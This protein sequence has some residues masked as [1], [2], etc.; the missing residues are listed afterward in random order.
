MP[1]GT[2]AAILGSA[3][4]AG[5]ASALSSSSN[6]KAINAATDAQSQ[7]AAQ[8]AQLQREIY[9][10]NYNVLSPYAQSGYGANQAINA[11]L[12]IPQAN[13]NAQTGQA[14]AT[15]TG[16]NGVDWAAYVQGNQ[17]AMND[18]MR[19]HQ[20]MPLNA[21][22]AYHYIAD[23]S[24]RDLSA[25]TLQPQAQTQQPATQ[26][27]P[28]TYQTAFD[29]YRNST[30]YQ[31][32]VNEGMKSLNSGY[33]ARGLLNSGAA[34]KAALEYGQNIASNEFNNYLGAL[35]NQQSLG[36]SAGSALAGV[37]QNYANSLGNINQ[38]KADAISNG[39]LAS[40]SNRNALYGNIAGI[41][42][43]AIGGLSSYRGIFG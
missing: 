21:Y 13:A 10:S 23:G 20:D 19:Y 25:Y 40:A 27:N 34:Q 5:G 7:A 2:T 36:L 39:A 38:N 26:T 14:G 24:R 17:D 8:N 11:L 6:S 41:A 3:I 12:G 35:G 18:Y 1:I 42:G 29:N 9:N 31:F 22:G 28:Q 15:N 30:G 4:I 16:V 33:A 32:R 37:G 43:N